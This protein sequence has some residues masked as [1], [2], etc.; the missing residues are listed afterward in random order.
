[1]VRGASAGAGEVVGTISFLIPRYFSI[2]LIKTIYVHSSREDYGTIAG[3]VDR[4]RAEVVCGG[5]RWLVIEVVMAY[6]HSFDPPLM[7][8]DDRRMCES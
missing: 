7:I 3:V 5:W 1:M 8:D 2:H 6:R 4:R